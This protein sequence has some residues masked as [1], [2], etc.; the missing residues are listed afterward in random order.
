MNFPASANEL[1]D[2]LDR[3]YPEVV[4]EPGDDLIAIHRQAAKREV[5]KFLIHWRDK[6]V[7]SAQR[8]MR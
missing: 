8:R 3:I 1:V 4:P 2:E 6:K 7:R 5:V